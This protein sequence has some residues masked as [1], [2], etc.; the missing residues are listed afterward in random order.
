[1]SFAHDCH[2]LI[3]LGAETGHERLKDNADKHESVQSDVHNL[4]AS[5]CI[6]L[7]QSP[8]LILLNVEIAL[9]AEFHGRSQSILKLDLLHKLHP[10][11]EALHQV[12]D[13]SF[14]DF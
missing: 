12:I 14:I 7:G 10:L 13:E 9:R 4:C 2:L 5:I 8:R 1:M 6:S 11:V 3:D